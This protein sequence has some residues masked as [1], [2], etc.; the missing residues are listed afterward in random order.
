MTNRERAEARANEVDKRII[1]TVQSGQS[2]RV[3]AGAGAGKTYSLERVVDWLDHEKN[4]QY[5]KNGQ[6]VACITYTNAAVDVIADRLSADSFI[7]PSTIHTFAW[8]L[9]KQ[10]QS[11]LIKAVQEL[12]LL[13]KKTDGSD[14]PIDGSNVKMVSYSLGVRYIEEGT[15]YLFHDDVIKLFVRLLDNAKFRQILSK[16]YPII[17]I[18]EYQ[19]SFKVIMDQFLKHFIEKGIGPQFGLFGD[20]WQTIYASQGACGLVESDKLVVINK[21]A[22]FRSQEIIVNALNQIRPSLP[23]IS[24]SDDKDGKITI[25][26]TDE[27]DAYRIKKGYYKGELEDSVLF[28]CINDAIEKLEH[29]WTGHTKKLMLTHKMLAKQQGYSRV[30]ELLN[31]HLK[32][33]DDEHFLFFQNKVEPVYQALLENDPKQLFEALGIERRPIE[34]KKNKRQWRELKDNLSEA[35]QETIGDVLKTVSES[36]LIAL[37]PKIIFWMNVAEKEEQV[38]LYHGKSIREFYDITY[39]EILKAIEFFKPEADFSTDHG[40]KGEQY[41]NVFLVLGRGWNDYRFDEQLYLD[42]SSLD[43][44]GEKAYIRNRNLFYVCCSRPRKNLVILITVPMNQ[45]FRDYLEGVFG[46]ENI[47]SYSQFMS[48]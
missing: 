35:R 48:F 8:N 30:L 24:A 19:D 25:I 2:F 26:T 34:S 46:T 21:E 38:Q 32:N 15:L 40:V 20:S 28:S 42:P 22:N 16:K 33:K 47:I 4:A 31:D 11:S 13:P 41:D 37:P 7:K 6:N 12:Q 14:E 27:Y 3:E 36:R 1:E 39:S 44:K 43:E 10:F 18:D 9:I 29:Q 45:R 23:Q 17:L 5:R